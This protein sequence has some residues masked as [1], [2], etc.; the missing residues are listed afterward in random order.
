MTHWFF[1]DLTLQ[2]SKVLKVIPLFIVINFFVMAMN[3]HAFR[4]VPAANLSPWFYVQIP[5]A[6]LFGF[7]LF[8]EIPH[9]TVWTGAT[10]IVFGGFLSSLKLT[11]KNDS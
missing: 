2:D 11:M 10:F 6:A 4:K 1:G 7:L 8:E 3:Y 9:W 5:A